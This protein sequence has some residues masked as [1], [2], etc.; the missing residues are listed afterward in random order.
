MRIELTRVGLLVY[1]AN[2]YTTRGAPKSDRE[3]SRNKWLSFMYGC[4]KFC[5]G[6][7]SCSERYISSLFFCAFKSSD[8][9][10]MAF[11]RWNFARREKLSKYLKG[12]QSYLKIFVFSL[13]KNKKRTKIKLEKYNEK[14]KEGKKERKV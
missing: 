2:H 6:F 3:C 7:E 13:W 9:K 11:T 1:L 14:K 12:K 5:R 10:S 8:L 4:R